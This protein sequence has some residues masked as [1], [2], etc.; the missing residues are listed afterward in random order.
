M[1]E[2]RPGIYEEKYVERYYKGDVIRSSRRWDPSEHLNDNLT[3]SNDISIISDDFVNQNLGAM[4]YLI[5]MNQK[6]EI[7]SATIDTDKHRITLSLGSVFNASN[8]ST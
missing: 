3:I 6:Y 7:V 4:R 2:T 8:T 1:E 5:L